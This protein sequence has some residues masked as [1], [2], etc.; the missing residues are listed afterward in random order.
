MAVDI[1]EKS[2]NAILVKLNQIG[3]LTETLDA[4][5]MAQR[6]GMKAVISHRSGETGDTFIADLAVATNAGQIKTGAPSRV[7]R[8]AKYNRLLAIEEELGNAADYPGRTILRSASQRFPKSSPWFVPTWV[9]ISYEGCGRRQKPSPP[10]PLPAE[11]RATVLGVKPSPPAAR[12]RALHRAAWRWRWSTACAC[13][14]PRP[15]SSLC[16]ERAGADRGGG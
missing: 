11:G 16:P 3:T 4:I 5:A 14:P 13:R 8:V 6:A 2:A 9:G 12:P 15:L 1:Q 10:A 7:D